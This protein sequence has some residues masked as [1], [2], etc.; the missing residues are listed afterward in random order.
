MPLSDQ[1]LD[2]AKTGGLLR[3]GNVL[4]V[5]PRLFGEDAAADT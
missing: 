3:E 1:L 5:P 4:S 2:L